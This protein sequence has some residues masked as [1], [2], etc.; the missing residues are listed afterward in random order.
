MGDYTALIHAAE[1]VKCL[2]VFRRHWKDLKGLMEQDEQNVEDLTKFMS[3]IVAER[4]LGSIPECRDSYKALNRLA[5]GTY[6]V[7]DYKTRSRGNQDPE[8]ARG[9]KKEES[10]STGESKDSNSGESSEYSSLDE[11]EEPNQDAVNAILDS[12]KGIEK[13][14]SKIEKG[15]KAKENKLMSLRERLKTAGA[16]T[17]DARTDSESSSEASTAYE[18]ESDSDAS[19][20]E[21]VRSI[22]QR[23]GKEE[24]RR[25]SRLMAR[26]AKEKYPPMELRVSE[27]ITEEILLNIFSVANTVSTYVDSA[28]YSVHRNRRE[29]RFL[30]RAIDFLIAD[31]GIKQMTRLR[32]SEVLLRRLAAIH[33]A[34]ATGD[35]AVACELEE[36]SWKREMVSDKVRRRMLRSARLSKEVS[37][38]KSRVNKPAKDNDGEDGKE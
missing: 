2:S 26:L 23:K 32:A 21:D 17:S 11:A 35:W 19:G 6:P 1:G 34:E 33:E 9:K 4:G 24:R 14:L 15:R 38:L 16:G 12:L 13:R 10:V 5:K 29:A 3:A 27:R 22:K 8:G 30:G 18:S 36:T 28:R 20:A 37:S 7:K 25:R 31:L